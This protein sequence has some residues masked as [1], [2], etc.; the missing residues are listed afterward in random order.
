M[1]L[2]IWHL[3]SA[4]LLATIVFNRCLLPGSRNQPVMST[5]SHP[6]IYTSSKLP[7]A[8]TFSFSNGQNHHQETSYWFLASSS[9]LAKRLMSQS[10]RPLDSQ[11]VGGWRGTGTNKPEL[12]IMKHHILFALWKSVWPGCCAQ[13]FPM[14]VRW[15]GSPNISALINDTIC[16]EWCICLEHLS[17]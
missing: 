13:S 15:I 1:I 2:Y 3:L 14:M 10:F 11:A 5:H 9:S 7:T 4:V 16:D 8:R 17:P 6:S 12:C